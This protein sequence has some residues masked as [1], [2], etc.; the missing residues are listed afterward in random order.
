MRVASLK[1]GITRLSLVWDKVEEESDSLVSVSL[2]GDEE[3]L[4]LAQQAEQPG[5]LLQERLG[6]QKIQHGHE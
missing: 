5:T 4:I 6:L 2:E 1:E 3:G